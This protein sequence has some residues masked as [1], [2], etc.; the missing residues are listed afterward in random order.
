MS[1][2]QYQHPK[3]CLFYQSIYEINVA[4]RFRSPHRS[5]SGK[6]LRMVRLTLTDDYD[7]YTANRFRHISSEINSYQL[8]QLARSCRVYSCVWCE[9]ILSANP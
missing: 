9:I 8:L 4:E 7:M 3:Q 1:F 2:I 5:L 6:T